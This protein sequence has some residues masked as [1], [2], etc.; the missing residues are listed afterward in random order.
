MFCVRESLTQLGAPLE[1]GPGTDA[2]RRVSI[3][4]MSDDALINLVSLSLFG[5]L[6]LRR[7]V[8]MERFHWPRVVLL[9]TL[10]WVS[11]FYLFSLTVPESPGCLALP[12][13]SGTF[14]IS[15]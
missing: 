15:E 5:A 7:L 6:L 13:E 12:V 9:T 4:E 11:A 14:T 1:A 10:L 3:R 8:R 2:C